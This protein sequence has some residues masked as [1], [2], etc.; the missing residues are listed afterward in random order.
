V[1]GCD[2]VCQFDGVKK[3]SRPALVAPQLKE[4]KTQ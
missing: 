2:C 1:S 3:L 4:E